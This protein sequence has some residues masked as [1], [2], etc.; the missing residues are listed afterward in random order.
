[1]IFCGNCIDVLPGIPAGS[2]D[3]VLSDLPYGQTQN[4]WDKIIPFEPMWDALRRVT[5]PNA[6]IVLMAAQP[7][8]SHLIC[9]NEAEFRYDLIWRKNKP[10]GFLNAKKQPLRIHEHILVFYR[11]PPFFDPQKTQGHKPGN[12]ARRVQGSTNYGAQR[13]TEYG[14]S[15]ERY[16][17]SVLEV[18]IINND[19]PD[20][21]HPTQKPV[22][23]MA[24]L[25]RS[26]TRPGEMVLDIAAGAGTTGLAAAREG[27]KSICIEMLREY[28]EIAERRVSTK[29]LLTA[30]T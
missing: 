3:M 21:F 29:D 2:V 20:K 27:R 22:D 23:L 19:D 1:M 5:K 6:A 30:M 16:P 25:I 4:A 12:Y 8:A 18:P 26:Y 14:G 28:V 15:T 7:F 24:G 11:K 17:T 13:P 10:T 9:S